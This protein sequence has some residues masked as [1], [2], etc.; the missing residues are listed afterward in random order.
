MPR[1]RK[2]GMDVRLSFASLMLAQ[3]RDVAVMADLLRQYGYDEARL[4]EGQALYDHVR[5]LKLQQSSARAD[6]RV[7]TALVRQRLQQAQARYRVLLALARVAMQGD[8]GYAV[9]LGLGGMRARATAAWADQATRFY[10]NALA[11]PDAL[12]KLARLNIGPDQLAEGLEEVHALEQALHAQSIARGAALA[13]TRT[14]D[15]ALAEL[16]AWIGQ[17]LAVARVATRS[18]RQLL[19][20]FGIVV[21]S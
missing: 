20:M 3:T 14:R 10:T 7:A 6:V 21:P 12:A 15:A 1:R 16:Y 4:A 5:A 17:M 18:D 13:A 19:E 11:M 2:Q 8:Q 9:A